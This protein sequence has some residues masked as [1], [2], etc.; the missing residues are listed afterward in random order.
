M[1]STP[2]ERTG[3]PHEPLPRMPDPQRPS[4]IK[5]LVIICVIGVLLTFTC[6]GGFVWFIMSGKAEVEP[7]ADTFLDALAEGD[8]AAAYDQL[9]PQWKQKDS[10]EQF[11]QIEKRF[12]A[13]MGPMQ[14]RSVRSF[15]ITR[16]TDAGGE[17]SLVYKVKFANG[18]GDVT[19]SLVE[20]GGA[21]RVVSHRIESP[22]LEKAQTC[23]QCG[24]KNPGMGHFCTQ[25]G[26]ALPNADTDA[27]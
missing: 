1:D 22:L 14:S 13:V 5:V 18:D 15:N 12:R 23:T 27:P 2:E 3:P 7:A 9:A 20:S 26:A 19:L 10:V 17:A 6:I 21:W 4:T 16:T 11:E 25:C 8:Y 24:A